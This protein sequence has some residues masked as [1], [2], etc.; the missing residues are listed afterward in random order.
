LGITLAGCGRTLQQPLPNPNALPASEGTPGVFVGTPPAGPPGPGV[1]IFLDGDFPSFDGAPAD[2]CSGGL[3]ALATVSAYGPAHWNTPDGTR[4]ASYTQTDLVEHGY[5]IYTPLQ[6][7]YWWVLVGPR[8]EPTTEYVTMG[9]QVG[10]DTYVIS[11]PHPS[12]G[13]LYL[14]VFGSGDALTAGAGP[15]AQ[16]V[17]AYNVMVVYGE[18]PV[19]AQL[20]AHFP[21]SG[22]GAVEPGRGAAGEL[23]DHTVARGA[24]PLGPLTALAPMRCQTAPA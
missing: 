17:N 23:S 21:R 16:S 18:V 19:D 4:P 5:K 12:V 9:G 14:L 11:M 1:H 15:T 7:S 2:L 8:F 3:V 20:V 10:N 6:F 13:Q 22:P 24:S